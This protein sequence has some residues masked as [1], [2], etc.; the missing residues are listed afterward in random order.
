LNTGIKQWEHYLHILL[1]DTD[2]Y[3]RKRAGNV[4][5]EQPLL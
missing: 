5:Y 2:A 1:A 3:V 4:I